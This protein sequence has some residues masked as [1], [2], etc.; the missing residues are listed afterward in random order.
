[1]ISNGIVFSVLVVVAITLILA[2]AML[3]GGGDD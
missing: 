2:F 1:M 3:H